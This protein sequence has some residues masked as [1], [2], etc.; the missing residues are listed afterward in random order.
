MRPGLFC[1]FQ[2]AQHPCNFFYAFI[3]I[4]ID[5]LCQGGLRMCGFIHLQMM[6]ALG[7]NLGQVRHT[8][9][10]VVAGKTMQKFSDDF[11]NPATDTG[12]NFIKY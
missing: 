6:M 9:Y 12:I 2:A 11:G 4:E 5:D 3:F 7:R 10:L 8:K 1:Y